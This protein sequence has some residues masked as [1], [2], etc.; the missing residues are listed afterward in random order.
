MLSPSVAT[1]FANAFARRVYE[2]LAPGATRVVSNEP[3]RGQAL[4]LPST[5][6]EANDRPVAVGDRIAGR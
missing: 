5:L 3:I 6:L 2:E 1:C 4:V